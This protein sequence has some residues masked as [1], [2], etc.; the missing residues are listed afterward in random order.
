[1]Q[2]S[3]RFYNGLCSQSRKLFGTGYHQ[4][5]RALATQKSTGVTVKESTHEFTFVKTLPEI[6]LGYPTLPSQTVKAFEL[7]NNV[8]LKVKAVAEGANL[9][10]LTIG[11]TP[12]GEYTWINKEGACYYAENSNAFPLNRGLIIPGGNR[13]AAVSANHGPYHDIDWDMTT[14]GSADGSEKSIILQ[15]QDTQATRDRAASRDGKETENPGFSKGQ[16][17]RTDGSVPP[18]VPFS[19]YPVTNLIYT[20]TITVRK[21]EDFVRLNMNVTNP[22]DKT[23]HAEAWLSFTW[24]LRKESHI[25]SDQIKRWRKDDGALEYLAKMI[26]CQSDDY[27]KF[28]KPLYWETGGV[29]Y[30]FPCKDGYF[31]GCTTATP[32]QG[33]VFVTP[34]DQPQYT[35]MWNY[36]SRET[37]DRQKELEKVPPLGAGRPYTEYYEPWSSGFNFAFF[38]TSQFEPKMSYSWEVAMLPIPGGLTSD[39]N[40]QLCDQVR[41]EIMKRKIPQSLAGVKIEPMK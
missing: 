25:F 31:H 22:T 18:D 30:D 20:F 13:F 6:E 3:K 8:G 14:T 26:D 17:S 16:W 32:G 4:S 15:I 39:D 37:F 9:I 40:A 12:Y 10:G 19:K 41:A 33:I 34:S 35:K 27:K 38:E 7:E 11:D 1:M 23:A 36:G 2:S 21:D 28:H 29:L 24:P 5:I